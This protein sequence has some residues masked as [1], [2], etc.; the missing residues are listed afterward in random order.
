VWWKLQVVTGE[1][2]VEGEGT[3]ERLDDRRHDGSAGAGASSTP[4]RQQ[5]SD[6]KNLQETCLEECTPSATHGGHVIGVR[7]IAD[8]LSYT[9]AVADGGADALQL[10]ARVDSGEALV[11]EQLL[12]SCDWASRC[13]DDVPQE[14]RD[15]AAQ[16]EPCLTPRTA[17]MNELRALS[18][19][20]SL[21][22]LAV[23]PP[24]LA[25][26]G[27]ARIAPQSDG[28]AMSLDKQ[29]GEGCAGCVAGG[30][31]EVAGESCGDRAGCQDGDEDGDACSNDAGVARARGSG[32]A[33]ISALPNPFT[34]SPGFGLRGRRNSEVRV[35]SCWCCAASATPA[36]V[37]ASCVSCMCQMVSYGNRWQGRGMSREVW[38]CR[39]TCGMQ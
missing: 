9:A 18:H 36:L 1:P 30:G 22:T 12:L 10:G 37:S 11:A 16:E 29:R 23:A 2:E 35:S 26:C 25:A 33:R 14:E 28:A 21:G 38:R 7:Q 4:P 32:L 13:D 24:H 34:G 27:V 5:G 31:E 3:I 8:P 39:R 17:L 19:S 15:Q 20:L 6:M